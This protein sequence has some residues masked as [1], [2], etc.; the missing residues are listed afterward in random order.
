[1]KTTKFVLFVLALSTTLVSSDDNEEAAIGPA[2]ADQM[3]RIHNE[4][5]GNVHPSATNMLQ[6][7]YDQGLADLAQKWSAQCKYSH[8]PQPTTSDFENVG[9]NLFLS[10]KATNASFDLFTAANQWWSEREL[11]DYHKNSC[12]DGQVCT[13]YTQMVWADS[14]AL[15]CGMSLCT[16]MQVGEQLL[17]SAQIIVCNYGPRGN[18]MDVLPYKEGSG[19]SECPEGKECV[20]CGASVVKLSLVV[21]AVAVVHAFFVALF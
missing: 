9:E 18:I 7:T 8:N 20:G 6:M 10:T 16:N 1:M 5:R 3:T 21:V 19:C 12:E 2:A 13:H 14:H 15:G 11:F 17:E 4:F